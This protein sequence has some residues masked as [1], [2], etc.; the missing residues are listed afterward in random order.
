MSDNED[1]LGE[2]LGDHSL[3]DYNL[4]NDE[5]DQLLADDY[6]CS[7]SHNVPTS[8]GRGPGGYSDPADIVPNEYARQNLDYRQPVVYMPPEAECV[9]PNITVEVP[10][11]PHPEHSTYAPYNEHVYEQDHAV[12]P[13]P[14]PAAP[15]E[16]PQIV[17]S[18]MS[19]GGNVEAGRERLP[20]RVYTHRAPLPRNIPDSLDKVFVPRNAYGGGRGRNSWRNPQ[21]RQNHPY[22]RNNVFRANFTQRPSFPPPQVRLQIPN[23]TQTPN[24]PQIQEG[25]APEIRPEIAPPLFR[26]LSPDR[27]LILPPERQVIL[28]EQPIQPGQI[29][30]TE[31]SMMEP[32]RLI[33]LPV[34]QNVSPD[35]RMM[36]PERPRMSPERPVLHPDRPAFYLDRP[37]LH[38]DRSVLQPDRPDLHPNRHILHPERPILHPDSSNLQPDIPGLHPVRPVLRQDRPILH[39]D[40]PMLNSDMPIE[41]QNF[42][43]FQ[44]RNEERY[45][46]SY[47]QNFRPNFGQNIRPH[48]ERPMYYRPYN[49]R[50]FGPPMREIIPNNNLPQVTI[51][52]SLPM[53]PAMR[54]RER[55]PE[56]RMLPVLPPN[57]PNL[58][59]GGLAGKK[60][61]INPHFKGNFQPPVDGLPAYIPTRIQ[62]TPPLSPTLESKFGP[63][64]DID[65][66]AE[67]FIAEQRNALARAA[68][69]KFARRSPQ[70]YIENTTIEIENDLARGPPPPRRR[71]EDE[72]L[73]RRQEEFINANRAGLRRRMRSPTPPR[74]S[75]ERR[76]RPPNDED[77]EYRRKVREQEA[78]REHVLRAKEVRR[79]KNAVALQKHLQ[80]REKEKELPK[81]EQAIPVVREDIPTTVVTTEAQ[82]EKPDTTRKTPEREKIE[83]KRDRSPIKVESAEANSTCGGKLNVKSII[84]ENLTPPRETV[85]QR[86]PERA[87]TPPLPTLEDKRSLS[88]DELD[89]ILDDIDDILSD[90]DDSGRFKE[91]A[92]EVE[93]QPPPSAPK[94]QLDLR[95]KLPP[96][97]P[98]T[99]KPRQKI[100]FNDNTE[101]KKKKENSPISR[102]ALSG[103]N[104]NTNT[105]KVETKFERPEKDDDK[106]KFPN[107]RVILQ[108]KI[109]TKEKSVFSRIDQNDPTKPNPGIFSR[110]VRTAIGSEKTRIV[111]QNEPTIE[112]ESGSDIDEDKLLEEYGNLAIVTNLPHGMTD[113]RLNT[114]AGNDVQNLSLDKEERSAKIT[115]KTSVAAENFKKKFNNKMV[116][117]SRLT[118][119]LK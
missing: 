16:S 44:F 61:L 6:D 77:N 108:R 86:S 55:E 65:D 90:E 51:R 119:S 116:A 13:P 72:D 99:K 80:E 71:S 37:D 3:A 57:L 5:E 10:N 9:V 70:R 53:L 69:R 111:I 102:T 47:G 59:P 64:K 92:K 23:T 28:M 32:E 82:Q 101:D 40:R 88:D 8:L 110:A 67:R 19:V 63:I 113:T 85:S 38:L 54:G 24:P 7:T 45:G 62:K 68:G 78:L 27:P 94:M 39:P 91:K 60:V 95:S 115:F 87:L 20:Q 18:E 112:Y 26:E 75:P 96:K 17:P 107:R 14:I 46:P 29:I 100:V 4:G 118:V 15:V 114:L 73:L 48:F 79:R 106:P 76:P 93:P 33:V 50:Q 105:Q 35:R 1:L 30:P 21:Y 11:T 52:Q 42:P 89:L 81:P 74:R 2:D 56:V 109:Q 98:E 41:N 31:R 83:T 97:L 25:I 104:K 58:P 34:R 49:P 43:R 66:A 12:V 22:R 117:A 84:P 103:S 36:S